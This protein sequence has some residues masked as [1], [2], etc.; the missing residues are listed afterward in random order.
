MLNT[1]NSTYVLFTF[2]QLVRPSFTLYSSIISVIILYLHSFLIWKSLFTTLHIIIPKFFRGCSFFSSTSSP[3]VL[4]WYYSLVYC[5]CLLISLFPPFRKSA[6]FIS[7]S[8]NCSMFS[9]LYPFLSF[10]ICFSDIFSFEHLGS[11]GLIS[12]IYLVRQII[13][14]LCRFSVI[15]ATL[16]VLFIDIW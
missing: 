8:L 13:W 3:S 6:T 11:A 14:N 12:I 9:W 5:S 4:F 16:Y 1:H 15:I 7:W 10:R 2:C